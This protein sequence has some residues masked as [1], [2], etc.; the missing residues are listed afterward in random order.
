MRRRSGLVTKAL[1]F[2]CVTTIAHGAATVPPV[3]APAEAA[4]ILEVAGVRGGVFVQIGC[5]DGTLAAALGARDGCVV[6]ALDTGADNVRAARRH[7]RSLGLYGRVSAHRLEGGRLPYAD[8]LVNLVVSEDLGAVSMDEVLRVL[9]PYGVAAIRRDGKWTR[10]VKPWPQE[11][12]EWTH[13]L[14]DADNNAV[15]QDAV[16]GPPRRLQWAGKPLWLRS[17]ETN[18][19]VSA[20]VSARGRVFYIFD[21]GPIG[22]VDQR[23]P[24]KWAL[25]ARDAFNGVKLWRRP[26][27]RWG[28]R[29]WGR[30]QFEK[31]DLTVL[32][33]QRGKY[34]NT[35][36][37][38]LVASGDRVFVTLG[39]G[40]PVSA[41]DATTGATLWTCDKT[42]NAEEILANDGV[43]LVSTRNPNAPQEKR[44][45][46]GSPQ[47]LVAL[48]AATGAV[49]WRKKTDGIAQLTLAI[50]DGRIVSGGSKGITCR[51]LASGDVIWHTKRAKGGNVTLVAYEDVV[52]VSAAKVLSAYSA[53]T[54]VPMW[55][56]GAG[57]IKGAPR[58]DLFVA[59]GLVWRGV[60]GVGVDLRTGEVKR[61]VSTK[62]LRSVGHHARCYRGKATDRFILSAKEG[63]E[64]LDIAPG[65]DG[66]PANSRNNW[67]RGSCKLGVMPANGLLYVPPDQCFCEP[68]VK[69]LGFCALG[70]QS[71]AP[72]PAR[73]RDERLVRGPAWSSGAANE[74][75]GDAASDDWPTFRHD[76]ARSGSTPCRV[77]SGVSPRW[78]IGL[79]GR[80]TAPVVADGMLLV[81]SIDAHTVLA[82]SARDGTPRWSFTAGGRIDS[83]PTIHAG[84]VLFGSADG[85]VYCLRAGDGELIWRFRAAPDER[86]V[87]AFGQ[88]ESAWP[89]HGSVLVQNGIAYATAG[90]SSFLDGG[91]HVHGLD[92]AT[93]RVLHSAL[94]E[95]PEPDFEDGPGRCFWVEGARSE[96]LVGDGRS[97]YMRQVELDGELRAR[98]P[99]YLT[100]MGDH[101]VGRHLFST[102]GLLDDEWYNRSFWMHSARWPG[103]YL[104]NQAP[105]S[106]QL[107]V[108]DDATTWAVKVFHRRNRHSPMFFPGKEGYLLFADDIDNEPQLVGRDGQPK[109]VEWLPQ[110][111]FSSSKGPIP[112]GTTAV[113]RD[114]GVGFT[115]SRP[116]KW[117]TWIPVRIQAMVKTADT[118]F[119]A[120]APDVL[121]E[122]DPLAGL[123]GRR[124]GELRAVSARDGKP[125]AATIALD[126]P[127][128][129]DG[130]IAAAGCLYLVAKDG[131]V[132]C[133]GGVPDAR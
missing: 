110:N 108:F 4:R 102:S 49:R 68:G 117:T 42:K 87:G 89:V 16:V 64:F 33:G 52:L 91:I 113:D 25:I 45:G 38:R 115:R 35:L 36:S 10:T 97:V 73:A 86:L 79:G 92:P 46:R 67:L 15:A 63:V 39:F 107:I 23:L 83:P 69:L 105:K 55:T 94:V 116:P 32:S 124:G 43:L 111:T 59:A 126:A 41:L 114:K 51:D 127:P 31:K 104:A 100:I 101:A 118:L 120:G 57:T 7:I 18:S 96:V 71:S 81:A 48:D 54:G 6:H 34:P 53:E 95:G 60:G 5:G 66:K 12:D 14:H 21:E 80:L 82:R 27:P 129:L 121:D 74:T 131:S 106:G 90:R 125:S 130:L 93:G 9:C 122:A 99:E 37:R 70:P 13:Y 24:S 29:A 2:L 72:S 62:N 76:A 84:R 75:T 30:E 109:P 22:I 26:M 11:I 88:L 78:R 47:H 19:G 103:F 61:K 119:V 112:V 17:H 132:T 8:G 98:K 65:P 1:W 123:Q 28:W 56:Q 3:D 40:A 58:Q 133:F 20:L 44:R 77:P 85:Q 128:V 50:A